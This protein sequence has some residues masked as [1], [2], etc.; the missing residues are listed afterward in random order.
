[1]SKPKLYLSFDVET[2]GNC[3]ILNNLISIGFYGI[4]DNLAKIFEYDANIEKLPGHQPEARCMNEFWLDPKNKNAWNHVNTNKRNYVDV[5]LELSDH[6][7]N[8]NSKYKLIFVASPSCFDWM[9]FKCYYE[10]VRNVNNNI[11]TMYD[12]GYKCHCGSALWDVYREKNKLSYSDSTVLYNQLG[13]FNAEKEHFALDDA[14]CQALV[15]V[16]IKNKLLNN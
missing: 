5:F 16:K 12:I 7:K 15:Y 10:M 9:F 14:R 3:P 13:E 2:D 1:M 6:F 11:N 4:D 8:L